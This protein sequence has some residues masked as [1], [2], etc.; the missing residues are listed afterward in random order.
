MLKKLNDKTAAAYWPFLSTPCG[1]IDQFI[2]SSLN[3]KKN[4]FE[5]KI[6]NQKNQK[7]LDEKVKFFKKKKIKIL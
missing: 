6:Q 2:A 4:P 1:K 5:L 7:I 3:E